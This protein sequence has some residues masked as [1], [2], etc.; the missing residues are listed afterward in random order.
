MR[1]TD[2]VQNWRQLRRTERAERNEV[3]ASRIQSDYP[4]MSETKRSEVPRCGTNS[5]IERNS[6]C[7]KFLR[8]GMK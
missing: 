5:A 2:V 7:G 6:C 4:Q 1:V 8:G 3:E